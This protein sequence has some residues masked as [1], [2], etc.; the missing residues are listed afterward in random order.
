[1]NILVAASST[2]YPVKLFTAYTGEKRLEIVALSN[3]IYEATLEAVLGEAEAI[4]TDI[5]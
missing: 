5:F 4:Q 1:M 3:F 2:K